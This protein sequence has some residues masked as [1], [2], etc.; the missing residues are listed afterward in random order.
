MIERYRAVVLLA[1]CVLFAG[2][3]AHGE[4]AVGVVYND[5]NGN[6]L[7]DSHERG[8]RKVLVSN[9]VDVVATDKTG[10]YALSV[11]NDT[12][13]FVIKPRGWMTPV[14]PGNSVPRFY[15]I[16]KP[17]GSPRMQYAGVAPTGSLPSSIDFPLQRQRERSRF[18]VVCFGDTQVRNTEEVQFLSHDIL[19]GVEGT[20]AVFGITLGDIVFN[21]LSVFDPLIESMSGVGIPWRYVAGNHDHNHDAPTTE[22]TDDTFERLF[23]PS[24]YS[25]N[26]GPVHFIV[27]NDIRHDPG[28][29]EYHGGLGERQLAFVKN[30]L[31]YVSPK[32][33]VV[34]LMHIPITELDESGALYALLKDF[35]HTFSL[36]AHSHRQQHVFVD[37]AA[38]WLQDT[39]HH[40]LNHGTACGSWWG[41]SLDETGIPTA[42]MSDGGP[43]NYSFITFS[44]AT[45]DVES[46]A[47]RMPADYQMNIWVP[48]RISASEA[49]NTVA[50]AN[51]FAGSSKSRVEMRVDNENL[52]TPMQQ[53][54]GKDPVFLDAS[55]RQSAF[56]SKIAELKGLKEDD[57]K[58]AD[59]ALRD[60]RMILRRLPQ[61]GDTDHLWRANLAAGLAPGGHV[62][63]IRTTDMFG[64]TYSAKRIFVVDK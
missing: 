35:P 61:P 57:K 55:K 34:L 54:T 19:E 5:A 17:S 32:Q 13:V 25:F 12:I 53:F 8:V 48:E 45:Y 27:L 9:G 6:G 62:L 14:G 28:R 15:Y 40:H 26:Y 51:V 2:I 11:E 21:D 49:G 36:S 46:R 7:R 10:R 43:N 38:G 56:V 22:S 3:T 60:F 58:L 50:I 42:Q 63:T 30:D 16:H 44:G 20:D 37:K 33:L 4:S 52:W 24:Y 64:R 18:R 47:A 39:P 1:A 31:A 41:G 29:E 59:E 23:G